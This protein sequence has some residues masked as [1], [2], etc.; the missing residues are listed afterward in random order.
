MTT[1]DFDTG[2]RPYPG[3]P[4]AVE[5]LVRPL[6]GDATWFEYVVFLRQQQQNVEG[7]AGLLAGVARRQGGQP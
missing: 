4:E 1:R 3:P 7:L 2:P 6:V 5:P